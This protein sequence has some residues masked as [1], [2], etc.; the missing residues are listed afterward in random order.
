MNEQTLDVAVVPKNQPVSVENPGTMMRQA[1]DVAGACREI[2]MRT[3]CQIQGRKYVKCE[4]WMAIA[5]AHGC[6]ASSRDVR[7]VDGG[8]TAI[9]E[10]R[11]MSDGVLLSQAEGFVGL[12]EK[13]WGNCPEYA[14]RAMAQTRAISRACRAAFAHVVVMI[15]GGLSTTPA[16]E[17]PDGGFDDGPPKTAQDAPKQ[18]IPRI[19]A[20]AKKTYPAPQGATSAPATVKKGT[21]AKF[22]TA[23]FLSNCRNRLLTLVDPDTEWAWWKYAQDKSWILPNESLADA[24]AD[25]MF[26]R[27]DLKDI[28]ASV[29]ALFDTHCTAVNAMSANCPPEFHDEIMRGFVPMPRLPEDRPPSPPA[30]RTPMPP[31]LR[32]KA[33]GCPV[34]SST[35]TTKHDDLVG[36]TWCKVCG[37][38]WQDGSAVAYEEHPWMFAKLPFAPKDAAKKT[39]KGMTLGQLARIDNKYWFGI[40][41]N[42]TAEPYQGRPPSAESVKFG[43]ACAE[44]RK[45]LDAG[46][47]QSKA[48]EDSRDHAEDDQD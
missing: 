19:P 6:I 11:R 23:A 38:Q 20:P 10:I 34:C 17:V 12:D 33:G 43:E 2:V 48:P 39:Y 21:D 40:V 24:T 18:A 3:A 45:H 42:F 27:Y 22:D 32:P 47:E 35:A 31:D 5:T 1:T 7:K 8:W 13:K 14:S 28:R 37:M 44:A 9:G 41:M 25:K 15:D 36:V 29:A 30:S 46:K 26:E 16:E 4:G